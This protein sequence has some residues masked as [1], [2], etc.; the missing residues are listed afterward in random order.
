MVMSAFLMLLFIAAAH[1][2]ATDPPELSPEARAYIEI[3]FVLAK[4][5]EAASDFAQAAE[6]Y[7]G[8]L[9]KY[10]KSL[11]E[12]YH[13]LGL[14]YYLQRKYEA[15]IENFSQGI[16]LKPGMLGARLLL[17]SSY[18]SIEQ[19]EKALPHLRYAHKEKASAESA[20]YLGLA[21][22]A[23]K[24][25]AAA[26]RYFQLALKNTEQ[27]DKI[28]YFIGESYLKQSERVS[29]KLAEQYPNS[30]YD[31]WMAAK[32][33]DNQDWHELAATEYIHAAKNDPRNASLFYPLA[34]LLAILGMPAASQLALERYRQ[35]MPLDRKAAL[36][37]G[38]LPKTQPSNVGL[39]IDYEAELRALT[40]VLEHD[41]PPL[42]M[43][44]VDV[45]DALGK[46][47]ASTQNG[48]W[49]LAIDHLLHA[50]WEQAISALGTLR[51]APSDWLRDYLTVR[52]YLWNDEYHKAEE[53]LNHRNLTSQKS[54]ALEMLRWEV[55]QQLSFF[56][57]DRLLHE[58]PQSAHARFVNARTLNARGKREALEE[59]QAAIEADSN[60]TEAR[61]A[62]ADY[63]L[64]NA[65][66]EEALAECQMALEVS[67]Y[68]SP[69]KIRIG[70]IYIKLR[71]AKKGIPYLEGALRSEPEDAQAR[72]DL[73]RGWELLGETDKAVAEYKRALALDPTLNRLH[74]V[75]ARIYRKIGKTDLADAEYRTFKQNEDSD[76]TKHLERVRHLRESS[77]SEP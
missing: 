17:G 20:T 75:L 70:R 5:A 43:L 42:P 58:Y 44:N 7:E 62:L 19:P 14:V 30:Q 49:K 64:S 56:Y 48:T 41:V 32:I 39:R 73:A 18:L 4:R 40:P 65:K 24:N 26:N 54:P 60:F 31:Y 1:Q 21:H 9:K 71:D 51:V 69:A 77:E 27:K 29:N 16:Q 45:N 37:A 74:Y 3:H 25:Y 10:P 15:A 67:A 46:R 22:R 53:I 23:L 13:N 52:A 59:Y 72:A 38:N 12:A 57:F 2:G 68:S 61:I 63:Y 55:A 35:L 50:R 6:E 36:D 76:R 47:L 28:L 66:Y 34:R 33:L 8:I 11:P